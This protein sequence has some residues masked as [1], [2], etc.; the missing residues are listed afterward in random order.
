MKTLLSAVSFAALL[1]LV[2]CASD[3]PPPDD[4]NAE[5]WTPGIQSSYP[6]WRL[7]STLWTVVHQ[8][9]LSMGFFRQEYWSG[10][11]FH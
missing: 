11:P 2:S 5:A 10:L 1:A 7:F 8:I 6:D 9:P 4:E 3:V